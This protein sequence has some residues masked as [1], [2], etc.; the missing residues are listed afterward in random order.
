LVLF[1]GGRRGRLRSQYDGHWYLAI[2]PDNWQ[3]TNEGIKA[4]TSMIKRLGENGYWINHLDYTHT[5]I[6]LITKALAQYRRQKRIRT[7]K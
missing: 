1:D 6:A 2:R 5:D 7:A 4:R 3:A